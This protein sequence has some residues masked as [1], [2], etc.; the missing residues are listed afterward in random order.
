MLTI[1]FENV[2]FEGTDREREEELK[3][4]EKQ[5]KK[6]EA[7]AN[8]FSECFVLWSLIETCVPIQLIS[9]AARTQSCCGPP[10]AEEAMEFLQ[11]NNDFLPP[12]TK[13]KDGHFM[14]P[15]IFFNVVIS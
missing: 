14:N 10:R 13:A 7:N 6:Y 5:S 15:F 4:Q 11:I 2:Q 1:P 3:R 12:A 9:N 8:T